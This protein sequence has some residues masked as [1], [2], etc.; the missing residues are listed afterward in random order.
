MR[1][2]T[3]VGAGLFA[4]WALHDL[5]ELCT[6]PTTSREMMVRAP[7]W[8]PVPE[9]V[10]R[11]G[12]SRS[13]FRAAVAVM[14]AVVAAAGADGV[15]SE[16]R[17]PFFR[18]ALQGFGWHGVGHLAISAVQRRYVSGVATAPVVV[19]PYWLWAR[20]ALA[21]SGAP[22]ESSGLISVLALPPVLIGAHAVA[23][24]LTRNQR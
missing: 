18:L 12:Y 15:R 3:V 23:R 22:L 19:I 7:A 11:H 2:T 9:D 8:L 24:T 13:H 20:R 16:G 17:S 1:T 6:M 4:A 5:E 21:R 14:A 10:R